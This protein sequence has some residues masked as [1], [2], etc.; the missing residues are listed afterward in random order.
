M[1][2]SSQ[3]GGKK[4]SFRLVKIKTQNSKKKGVKETSCPGKQTVTS[5]TIISEGGPAKSS[6]K[7]LSF[8]SFSAART[9]LLQCFVGYKSQRFFEG[10]SNLLGISITIS[11]GVVRHSRL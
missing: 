7:H 1:I 6:G 8:L 5:D 2:Q 11:S 4:K 3:Q 10:K 9:D